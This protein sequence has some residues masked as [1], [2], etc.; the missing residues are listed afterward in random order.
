VRRL[1]VIGIGTG[2]PE[3]LTLEA[4]RAIGEASV[5]FVVTKGT[6]RDELVALR[7]A[8]LE[9]HAAPGHRVVEIAD[10]PRERDPA[11]YRATV[12]AWRAERGRRWERALAAELGDGETGAFLVWGDPAFYDSTL[13]ILDELLTRGEVA[14]EHRVI[15]GISAPQALA[16]A[17][18]IALNRV[19]GAITITPARRLPETAAEDTVVMLDLGT[20]FAAIEEPG[21]EI[22]WG[23]YLGSEDELLVSGPLADAGP[24]IERVRAQAK[25]RKGW[26]FDTYL[27]RRPR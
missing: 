27:L 26:M 16:A 10:P 2:N 12:R 24:E 19:G 11:D 1:L 18:R 4:V 13:E 3:H 15:P 6:D 25:A 9:A 22:F 14:F 7:R 8:M 21:V 5:F 17:H 20:A 23:A